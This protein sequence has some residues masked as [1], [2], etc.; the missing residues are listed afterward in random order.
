MRST[1][2]AACDPF[3]HS[4]TII[5]CTRNGPCAPRTSVISMSAVREAPDVAAGVARLARRGLL[6]RCL[7]PDAP[8]LLATID[9][10]WQRV[11]EALGLPALALRKA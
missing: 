4:E 8:A 10:A 7:A 2:L 3:A 9:R 6:L 1:L 11:R 5:T